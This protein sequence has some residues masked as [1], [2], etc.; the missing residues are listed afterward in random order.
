[1]SDKYKQVYICSQSLFFQRRP[2]TL[3][4]AVFFGHFSSKIR[5]SWKKENLQDD[6]FSR[7]IEV[8]E[9]YIGGKEG[10]KHASKK[11]KAGRGTVG[12]IA[13]AG[14]KDRDTNRVSAKVVEKTDSETLHGFISDKEKQWAR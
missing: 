2:T 5:E 11:L 3:E 6:T 4:Q 9:T 10:N 7:P 1:M 14:I 13:V 12:K 8:D